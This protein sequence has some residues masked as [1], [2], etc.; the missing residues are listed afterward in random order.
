MKRTD[1]VKEGSRSKSAGRVSRKVG[2][3]L[4]HCPKLSRRE[5][6]VLRLLDAAIELSV[7]M[8]GEDATE[9]AIFEGLGLPEK[10]PGESH[11]AWRHRTKDGTVRVR[12][13]EHQP[14]IDVL[15]DPGP[16]YV[17]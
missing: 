14:F 1:D 11:A 16:R 13:E 4:D 3:N 5:V 10:V 6:Q 2:T 12:T 9:R 17:K 7:T 8:Y 15:G